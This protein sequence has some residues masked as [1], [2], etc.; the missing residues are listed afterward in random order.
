M[1]VPSIGEEVYIRSNTDLD[2]THNKKKNRNGRESGGLKLLPLVSKTQNQ[3]RF[4]SIYPNFQV[5]SLTGFAGTGKTFIALGQALLDVEHGLFKEVMIIR[6]SVPSR[7]L[8]F[9][10]GNKKEKMGEYETPY[11]SICT[12]LYGRGDAYQVLKQKKVLTF[13]SSSFLRG[14][15]FED[16]V[17][18]IDEAQNMSYQEL[19]TILTRVGENCKVIMCG[20]TRQDDL[21]NERFREKSGY[22]LMLK[23]LEMVPSCTHI[24]F[25]VDDIVRSGFVK[26][27]ILA[28]SI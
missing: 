28:T 16:S 14:I 18:V 7:D 23:K 22:D 2:T 17:I 4:F 8:G 5:V 24:E 12:K 26:E 21:T 13:E 20:D 19:Y 6:S 1:E 9:M 27:F 11:I 15:T 25:G 10:P 3:K